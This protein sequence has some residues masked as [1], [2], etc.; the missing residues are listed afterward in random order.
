MS[1]FSIPSLITIQGYIQ[2]NLVSIVIFII[3]LAVLVA[4]SLNKN[5]SSIL[6]SIFTPTLGD[7]QKTVIF[8]ASLILMILLVVLGISMSYSK[9]SISW[10]PT[11]GNC[12]DYWIDTNGDG[13]NCV[14]TLNLGNSGTPNTMNFNT[15]SFKGSNGNCRKNKWANHAS[16]SWDGINYGVYNPCVPKPTPSSWL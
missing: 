14:N 6:V 5:V 9:A 12:P 10:P 16:V 1:S 13:S 4:L 2:S 8:L 7:F 3:V 11:V 15:A